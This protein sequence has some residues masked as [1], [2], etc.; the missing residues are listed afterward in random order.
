MAAASSVL[1][2]G[3]ALQWLRRLEAFAAAGGA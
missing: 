1:D 2:G 3:Q